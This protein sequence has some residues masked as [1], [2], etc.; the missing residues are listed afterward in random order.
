MNKL[1]AYPLTIFVFAAFCVYQIHRYTHT[2][3]VTLILLTLFDLALIY[4][5]WREY[6][7]QK[8]IRGE[9]QK[10]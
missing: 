8:Q 3:S 9:R 10:E 6:L 2:H 1:W 7:E 5:T 4:L